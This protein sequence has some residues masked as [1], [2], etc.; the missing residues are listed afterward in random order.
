MENDFF[1]MP[2]RPE[3]VES[4]RER[5]LISPQDSDAMR[6]LAALLETSG[7]LPGAIDLNQRALRVDPYL[8]PA[9]LDLARLWAQ[10]GDITRAKSWFER[11][12]SID[13]DSDA[14]VAGLAVLDRPD[15]LTS[16]YIRTLFDQYAARFDNDLTGTLKY[17]APQAV[18]ALLTRCGVAGAD[19]LD[20]GCGTGLSGA[21]LLPFAK[22]LDGIDL[23]PQMIAKAKARGIYRDLSVGEAQAFLEAG[24]QDWGLI[25]AVDVLNYIGD[26]KPVFAAVSSR[27][28]PGGLF[29]GTVEK[30]E[31]GGVT[32]TEKRRHRH[33]EDHVRAAASA[34]GL[35]IVELV[36]DVLRHEGGKPVVGLIFVLRRSE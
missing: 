10:L 12:L 9:L 21:A 32:L 17:R 28:T 5:L 26:L 34:A 8:V 1:A 23:S 16:D 7:D 35:A 31:E 20:L 14:A 13:P 27:L 11:V 3:T 2:E 19:T 18:A 15:T 36:E 4:L 6:S 29:A 24:A 22:T 33:G 25:A 30:H